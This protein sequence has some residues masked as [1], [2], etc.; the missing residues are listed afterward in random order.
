MS[1]FR[2]LL[3]IIA[4]N[5]SAGS[6]AVVAQPL[7]ATQR[8]VKE[9]EEVAEVEESADTQDGESSKFKNA[10]KTEAVSAASDYGSPKAPAKE[11]ES[12]DS[13]GTPEAPKVIEYGNWENSALVTTEKVKAR[14]NG[15]KSKDG[16][17]YTKK[18]EKKATES[19]K[20]VDESQ[21]I[22]SKGSAKHDDRMKRALD[23]AKTSTP[24]KAADEYERKV[25]KYLK[26]KHEVKE[27]V[28]DRTSYQV[29]KVLYDHGIKYD[30]ARERELIDAINMAMIKKMAMTPREARAVMRDEDFLGDTMSELRH[31]EQGLAEGMDSGK[32]ARLDDLIDQYRTATDPEAYYGLDGEY[33]DP[34]EVLN[35]IRAEFGDRVAG[36]I[37]AGSDKMHFPRKDHDQGYDPMSWRKPIDRQTKAGKMYKQ[38]SDYRKNTIKSRYRLSGK[39]VTEGVA[40]GSSGVSV[41]QWANQVRKDHGPDVKFRNRQEGGGAVDSVIAKNSQGETVGVY[42]RTTGYPTVYEPKQGVAE[43]RT[44]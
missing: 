25:V 10:P 21:E 3:D 6:V 29:A 5:T 35:M 42:N 31:M 13:Q 15:T 39:S 23:R 44:K 16:S 41:R 32:R 43:G 2:K 8:R 12:K 24:R 30:P 22:A 26:K 14:R 33:E 37:E 7:G 18:L 1:E 28:E 34:E 27:G 38:D 4:E 9:Q 40:E 11:P 17:V 20:K 36:Q 19:K